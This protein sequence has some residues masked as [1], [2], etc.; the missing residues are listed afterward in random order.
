MKTHEQA[1]YLKLDGVRRFA[2][3][4]AR[5]GH[6][7][8]PVDA[9]G[10]QVTIESG[11]LSLTVV[12]AGG[13]LREL[14][15]G[16]WHV[17]DGYARDEVAP[18]AAGQPL[19]P[20]PNRLAGGSYEFGGMTY[21]VPWNEPSKRNAVHGFARWMTWRVERH[22]QSRARLS[23]V[24]YPRQ[25]Y[26]FVLRV[27]IDYKISRR[28]VTVATTARNLGRT[29]LPY[30]AGFHPY[31]STGATSIDDCLLEVPAATWLT[32]DRR[33]IP[34]GH[35]PVAGTRYDFRALRR[36]GAARLDTAFTDLRRDADGRVRIRLSDARGSRRVA[37]WMDESFGHVMVFTGD[38]LSDGS[39][40]RR[41][42]AVEPMTA[43]PNAFRS[44]D[45]L[46]ILEPGESF[47]SRWGIEV[48]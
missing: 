46:R 42:L 25:G 1:S 8:E 22:E 47:E 38:T 16:D 11:P 14:T 18:G 12:T 48:G 24:M 5:A 20:W 15:Y 28:G 3:S 34:T 35:A 10:E 23:L 45:G 2:G 9:S 37:L 30:A 6:G 36:I 21:N 33:Q 39:R 13:G 32:T 17:L 27:V 44:G 41:G 40:R 7:H 4:R 31:L 29:A 19:I 26:P 43:A